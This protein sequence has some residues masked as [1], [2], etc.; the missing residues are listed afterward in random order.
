MSIAPDSSVPG[1]LSA[2]QPV[3]V[4]ITETVVVEPR[5]PVDLIAAAIR[6][7]PLVAG[8]HAGWF[9]EVG[10]YLPGRR[11]VG[12]RIRS[13][14]V[15]VHVIGR[16]PATMSEIASQVRLAVA[17]HAERRPID[18]VIE[19]VTIPAEIDCE[20]PAAVSDPP[21][22]AI[23]V[24]TDAEFST[25]SSGADG[26]PGPGPFTTDPAGSA[27]PRPRFPGPDVKEF[28]S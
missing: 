9:G 10:T 12:V 13:T 24:M 19:D 20:V 11:V 6:D 3:T 22:S 26:L 5:E 1:S 18:V 27:L 28:S 8:L 2:P 7:C 15:E 25:A 21:G 16:Y 17:P 4:T 14:A 23:I